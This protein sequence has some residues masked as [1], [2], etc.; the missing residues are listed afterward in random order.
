MFGAI[1]L[2]VLSSRIPSAVTRSTTAGKFYGL[3]P[4]KENTV[5]G[6]IYDLNSHFF[7]IVFLWW[8]IYGTLRMLKNLNI[9]RILAKL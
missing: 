8:S 9:N 6:S 5:L 1:L 4:E 2:N 7:F 3:K